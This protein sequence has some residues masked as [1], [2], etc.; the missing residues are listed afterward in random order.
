MGTATI[1][2]PRMCCFAYT[3]LMFRINEGLFGLMP[4]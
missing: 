4:T 1:A 2:Y 3:L